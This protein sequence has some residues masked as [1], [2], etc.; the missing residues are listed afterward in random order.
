[1][2]AARAVTVS[3]SKM[4]DADRQVAEP[5]RVSEVRFCWDFPSRRSREG[6]KFRRARR[7]VGAGEV[8]F[9]RAGTVTLEREHCGE[10]AFFSL[11]LTHAEP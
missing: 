11:D 10:G 3:P 8:V 7:R 2:R 9:A 4:S 5:N 1:M 6:E